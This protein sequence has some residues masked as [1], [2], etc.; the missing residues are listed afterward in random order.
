[1]D[2]KTDYMIDESDLSEIASKFGD[3]FKTASPSHPVD[4]DGYDS[5]ILRMDGL[6]ILGDSYVA[7]LELIEQLLQI[8]WVEEFFSRDFLK[9]KV[10][11]IIGKGYSSFEQGT[12]NAVLAIRSFMN[13]ITSSIEPW[14]VVV[15]VAGIDLD[16]IEE[17]RIGSV[18]FTKFV[19][20]NR[21]LKL[22]DKIPSSN[23]IRQTEYLTSLQDKIVAVVDEK[24]ESQRA[25]EKGVCAVEEAMNILRF[26][27]AFSP[28]GQEV[29]MNLGLKPKL[30]IWSSVLIQTEREQAHPFKTPQY[31]APFYFTI[32]SKSL[33]MMNDNSIAT[34]DRILKLKSSN[35]TEMQK[36]ILN[37]IKWFGLA[38]QM[39]DDATAFLEYYVA[40]DMVLSLQR[41]KG[42]IIAKSVASLIGKDSGHKLKVEAYQKELWQI[43]N[44]VVHRGE[45]SA[46]DRRR[47]SGIRNTVKDVVITLLRRAD[48]FQ[49]KAH[50]Q[51]W[52]ERER[53]ERHTN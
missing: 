26:Y 16:G 28:E 52:L 44:N 47:L 7:Y 2:N 18:L 15:P 53:F 48:E 27:S 33:R 8:R 41:T 43:R 42:R 23:E 49:T 32:D 29:K 19:A 24:G 46:K 37:A 5:G 20:D 25:T 10:L 45:W 11:E 12:L 6:A 21:F 39:D 35:R 30:E 22:A 13:N 38:R 36:Q 17:F 50:L 51:E 14:G 40:L 4:L 1:M 3:I 31:I 34:L 9:Q